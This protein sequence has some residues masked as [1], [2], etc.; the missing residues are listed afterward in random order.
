MCADAAGDGW[1]NRRRA[2]EDE[3]FRKRDQELVEQARLRAE[4]EVALQRLADAAGVHDTD[5]LRDLQRLGYM[6]DTVTL[7]QVVPL[8][9]V[10]WADGTV[11]DPEREIIVAAARARG[12]EPGSRADRQVAEWLANPPPTELLDGTLH[13][14]GALWHG[15]QAEERDAAIQDLHASCAAVACASGGVLGFCQISAMEQRVI[16]G[17]LSE[18]ERKNAPFGL[19]VKTT[20]GGRERHQ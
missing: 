3:Y 4:D 5:T 15:H 2:Y 8:L 16:D 14:L 17:I 10:A 7:L 19:P 12:V 1:G 18:V 9:E 13:L 6:P 20:A 11:S